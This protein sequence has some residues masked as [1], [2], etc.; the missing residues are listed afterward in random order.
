LC[1]AATGCDWPSRSGATS[2]RNT[3]YPHPSRWPARVGPAPPRVF[4]RFDSHFFT[5]T[6][7]AMTNLQRFDVGPRISQIAIHNGVAYLAGQIPSDMNADVRGQ[8]AQ[9]LN[10]IDALLA[11]VGSDKTLIL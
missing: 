8:T 11:R 1:L 7:L 4:Q 6:R 2:Q 5:E 10:A 3:S 9:V